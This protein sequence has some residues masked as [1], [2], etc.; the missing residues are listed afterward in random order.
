MLINLIGREMRFSIYAFTMIP[1]RNSDKVKC[2]IFPPRIIPNK[3]SQNLQ[4]SRKYINDMDCVVL[5]RNYFTYVGESNWCIK[6]CKV[7]CKDRITDSDYW[8]TIPL[9]CDALTKSMRIYGVRLNVYL[10]FWLF[11]KCYGLKQ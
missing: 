8:F 6:W 1:F 2:Y 7:D 10:N 9:N 5:D 3:I 4:N 11:R